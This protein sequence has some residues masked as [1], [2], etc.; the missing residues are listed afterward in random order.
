MLGILRRIGIELVSALDGL[1]D[2]ISLKADFK[3][4]SA[5]KTAD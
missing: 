4:I 3:S 5:R 2:Q 1:L